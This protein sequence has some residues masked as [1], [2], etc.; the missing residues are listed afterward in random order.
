MSIAKKIQAATGLALPNTPSTA[1]QRKPTHLGARNTGLHIYY[2][3]DWKG[4]EWVSEVT[5]GLTMG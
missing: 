2:G 3:I 5:P 1:I 4:T